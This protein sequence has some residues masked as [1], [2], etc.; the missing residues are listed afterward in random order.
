MK[1]AAVM[2]AIALLAAGCAMHPPA[3]PTQLPVVAS[4]DYDALWDATLK[5]VERHFDLFVQR[6]DQGTMVSTYKRGDPLPSGA[7][8]RDAQT[9]YDAEEDLLHIT[10]RQLTARISQDVPGVYVLH[11]EIIRERQGYVPPPAEQ[12]DFGRTYD[13]YNGRKTALRDTADQ[14]ATVTWYRIGRDMFLEKTLL[15]RI[16][17]DVEGRGARVAAPPAAE[18]TSAPQDQTAPPSPA[19]APAE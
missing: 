8:A 12:Q 3:Q 10:R 9:C 17:R 14:A 15:E 4:S 2:M 13:I 6:R 5:N 1:H 7:L 19:D 18:E 11:M 16:G